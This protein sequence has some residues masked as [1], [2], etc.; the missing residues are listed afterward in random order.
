M[1]SQT[2]EYA[3]RAI[4]WLASNPEDPQTNQQIAEATLVPAGY[5]AKVMQALGR[6]GLVSGQRGKK[7]GFL[8]SRPAETISV[9]EVVNTVEPIRR[10]RQ[11]PLGIAAHGARLCPLHARLD[12]AMEMIENAFRGASIADVLSEPSGSRP[13]C[14]IAGVHHVA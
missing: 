12:S 7:G 8:L 6:G 3:L 5:L 13:L 10:I 1:L 11:C 2:V 9:L 14:R 4:V